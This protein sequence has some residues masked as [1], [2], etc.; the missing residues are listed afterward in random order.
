[1]HGFVD[2]HEKARFYY[3]RGG[4]NVPLPG[5]PWSPE[6]MAAYEAAHA[7][8]RQDE[9][10]PLGSSRTVSGPYCERLM[11]AVVEPDPGKLSRVHTVKVREPKV[12]EGRKLMGHEL[13]HFVGTFATLLAIINPLEVLP[14]Y[15]KMLEGR[16]AAHI[17]K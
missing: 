10:A 2:R 11:I 16:D 9:P 6:F 4:K 7:A 3:R 14:V 13:S 12:R 15:L 1:M 5:L 8:F 17:A